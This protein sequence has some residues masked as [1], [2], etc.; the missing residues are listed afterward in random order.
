LSRAGPLGGLVALML[1]NLPGL[2]ILTAFGVVIEAFVDPDNPPWYLIGLPPAAIALVFTAFYKFALLLD[3]LGTILALIS[4][5]AAILINN[6]PNISPQSSQFVFPVALALSGAITYI[7][8]K[9]AKPYGTYPSP[10][11]GWDVNNDE[12]TKRIGIPLWVG[13]CIFA[14]WLIIL[15]ASILLVNVADITDVYLEIFETM[16]RIGSII[17]GGGQV[18]LPL[19]QDEVVPKWMTS[20]QFLQ[21]LGLAQSMPGPLFNFSAYLGAVYQGVPGALIAFLGLFG[22]GVILIFAAVPFW[23]RLRHNSTFKSVLRGVNASAIGL[24][25]AACVTLWE[26]AIRTAADA[27]VF[28]ISLTLSAVFTWDAPFCIFTGGVVGAILHPDALNLGQRP[29]CVKAGFQVVQ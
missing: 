16:Y 28:S 18:V 20:D 27:M 22:P 9:R 26:S 1:W 24:V 6:D 10:G 14:S 12:M 15:I 29:Y 7:D 5:L 11:A 21:G 17:F 2:V 23:A 4:C 3:K 19:L 13:A 25:G 8:S